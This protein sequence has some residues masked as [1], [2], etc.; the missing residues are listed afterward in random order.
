MG[1][2]IVSY[3]ID[4]SKLQNAIINGLT[5]TSGGINYEDL[6]KYMVAKHA[7]FMNKHLNDIKQMTSNKFRE[8]LKNHYNDFNKV[9]TVEYKQII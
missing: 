8:F 6:M 5:Q 2:K 9:A 7:A 1:K 3:E 4:S